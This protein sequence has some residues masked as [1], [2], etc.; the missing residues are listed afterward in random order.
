MNLYIACAESN[1]ATANL[2]DQ[3]HLSN[4]IPIS[5]T[6]VKSLS[7]CQ[8]KEKA[9]V[10]SSETV[11]PM[12][13]LHS[14]PYKKRKIIEQKLSIG[15]TVEKDFDEKKSKAVIEVAPQVG[16]VEAVKTWGKTMEVVER[17]NAVSFVL[18]VIF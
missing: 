3:V 2:G 4:N 18:I 7:H 17:P 12:D 15:P 11:L 9:E 16:L 6:K 8:V 14:F 1:R 5:R 10:K 13:T